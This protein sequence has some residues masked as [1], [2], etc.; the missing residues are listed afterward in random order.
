MSMSR[1]ESDL[2]SHYMKQAL[3]LAVKGRGRT[4]PN[5]MV[6]A[7]VVWSGVVV[8]R[9][10]HEYVGGPHAEI[11][12][13]REAGLKAKN[14]SLYVTLEPCN[15]FGRTPPC[16][17]AILAAGI[18][19]VVVGMSDPNPSVKGGGANW[20]RENGVSVETGIMEKECRQ[21]NQAFIKHSTTGLPFVTL[22]AASTLD[23]HI[24]SRT[25]DSRWISNELSRRFVHGLRCAADAVLVGIDTALRDDPRLTSRMRAKGACRQPVRVI[26]DTHLRLPLDSMLIKTVREAPL[27]VVCGEDA[28]P[29]KAAEL[30][31]AGASVLWQPSDGGRID[32][33]RVVADLGGRGITSLLVEGGARVLGAFLEERLADEL[34]FFYAP[35]ILADPEG[36][37]VVSGRAREL[38]SEAIRVYDLDVRRFGE[39]VLLSGRITEHPY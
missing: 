5:P 22:K 34:H 7:V 33:G 15:H 24:A 12:A 2:D 20:L 26:L 28:S 9:G 18:K 6:G 23:G 32:L 29:E 39:D 3:R 16:T 11:N 31:S 17:Q 1:K 8:G 30:E 19:R 25:G 4:S 38:I 21:V 27:W 35:K 13:L 37:P 14:A 10:Y 36:V